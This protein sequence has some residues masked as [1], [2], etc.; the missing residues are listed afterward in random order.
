MISFLT[1]YWLVILLWHIKRSHL[2]LRRKI[3]TKIR[4]NRKDEKVERMYSHTK[5]RAVAKKLLKRDHDDVPPHPC[6]NSNNM[7]IHL[8]QFQN[9]CYTKH[10]EI[11]ASMW[12]LIVYICCQ[13]CWILCLGCS[14]VLSGFTIC[15]NCNV[16][17]F[18][19]RF[20][21]SHYFLQSIWLVSFERWQDLTT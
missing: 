16:K 9:T 7:K 20:Q 18:P 8:K 14:Q 12:I 1:V 3:S 2:K 19:K 11:F 15:A 5:S 4:N 10:Q 13:L 21:I 17:L 6:G